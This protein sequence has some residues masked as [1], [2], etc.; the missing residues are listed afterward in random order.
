LVLGR[1]IVSY[2]RRLQK[3]FGHATSK[4]LA[5]EKIHNLL[6]VG[7]AGSTEGDRGFTV[8]GA[9]WGVDR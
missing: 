1:L 7:V 3:K 6:D 4:N 2:R 8:P 9:G 5:G